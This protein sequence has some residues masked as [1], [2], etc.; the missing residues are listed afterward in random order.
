V[1]HPLI[2][3]MVE[4]FA[5]GR[6]GSHHRRV[7]RQLQHESGKTP[8]LRSVR[9]FLF[10]GDHKFPSVSPRLSVEAGHFTVGTSRI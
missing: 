8:D 3:G 5:L 1:Q 6:P 9:Q 10:V 4:V 7:A 2:A